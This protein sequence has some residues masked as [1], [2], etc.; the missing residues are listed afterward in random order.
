MYKI[1]YLPTGNIFEMP[2][3]EAKELK[4]K[5]PYEYK[6]MEKN[7]K[8]FNDKVKNKTKKREDNSVY[9]KVVEN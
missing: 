9:S 5:Y 7:G 1:Q 4:E 3:A 6:I 2:E 8:K